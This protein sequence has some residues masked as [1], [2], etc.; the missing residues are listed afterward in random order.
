MVKNASYIRNKSGG[1]KINNFIALILLLV[2]IFLG[3]YYYKTIN[4]KESFANDNTIKYPTKQN[5]KDAESQIKLFN[6]NNLNT[7]KTKYKKISFSTY[8]NTYFAP[9]HSINCDYSE[10]EYFNYI[11]NHLGYKPNNASLPGNII[12]NY[13]YIE[14]LNNN[15]QIKINLENKLK[16]SITPE[17]YYNVFVPIFK[18]YYPMH[19]G[20]S[21]GMSTSTPK[22][23]LNRF[24]RLPLTPISTTIYAN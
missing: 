13:D 23:F 22:E 17:I 20:F 9:Y 3:L 6:K 10:K 16:V 24:C 1:M 21:I 12:K 8:W 15:S 19:I 7:N 14:F 5:I 11:L 4:M 2:L 18:V